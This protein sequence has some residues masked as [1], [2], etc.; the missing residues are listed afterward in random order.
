MRKIFALIFILA[1]FLPLAG[2]TESQIEKPDRAVIKRNGDTVDLSWQNPASPSFL[3][4]VLFRSTIPIENF[5]TYKAV[6]GICD[7]IYEGQAETF[8][9]TGLAINLPYYYIL[10]AIDKTGSSSN[11][12]V[13]SAESDKKEGSKKGSLAGASSDIVNQISL[14]EA[15]S[16]YNYNKPLNDKPD[17]TT[18]RLALFIIVKSPHD[19]SEKDKNSIAYFIQAGTETTILLGNGERAG[20]LNSYL[21]VFNKL[22]RSILEWQDII[23]IANGRWPDQR[24]AVSEDRAANVF[25]SAIYERKP[26]MGDPKDNAAV[27][28]IAYGL[29][30]AARNLDS[31]KKAIEIYRSIF[32]KDPVEATDWDLVRAIAYSGATR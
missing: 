12:V 22:P 28:V 20:V 5:F 1:L 16:I 21:S 8:N 15:G 13:L 29:R 11:A 23:K 30:P 2:R 26:D 7:K 14:N 9:D 24:N 32:S 25:F 18:Q 31:E 27:T 17:D 19:L 4:T 6:E 3:K 10:F